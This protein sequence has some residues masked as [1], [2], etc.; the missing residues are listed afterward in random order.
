M[1]SIWQ[2]LNDRCGGGYKS[3]WI[4]GKNPRIDTSELRR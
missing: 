3:S 2:P 1:K 4:W